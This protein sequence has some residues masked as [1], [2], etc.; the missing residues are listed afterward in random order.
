VSYDKNQ[1]E[2]YVHSSPIELPEKT[3]YLQV[4]VAPG[5][6]PATGGTPSEVGDSAQV[7]IPDISSF[8]KVSEMRTQIVR[9][10]KQVPEQVLTV[11]L[12]DEIETSELLENLSVYL[13]PKKSPRWE[14]L[15]EITDAVL[16]QSDVV[17]LHLIPN[18]RN[19][20]QV[21]NFTYDAP[22]SRQLY[23]HMAK[24]LKSINGFITSSFSAGIVSTPEYPREI[25]IMGDGAMLSLDGS[26][27]LSLLARG[28]DAYQVRVGKLL[29][30]Q[31][32]H[33]VS[34]TRGDISDV[35][36][37]NGY[38]DEENI[39]EYSSHVALL[40]ELHP[41]TANYTSIDLTSYL[42]TE[43]DSF[44]LFF[45][46]VAGW[47]TER[48]RTISGASDSRVILVTD[49]GLLVKDNSDQSHDV[50]VQSISNG[51]PVSDATVELLGR[52]GLPI[53]T[54]TTDADGHVSFPSTQGFS[55]E[56]TPT[57]Y[58]VKSG[59]DLSFLPF[60][61]SQRELN[62][63]QFEVGGVR[64]TT[65]RSNNL[66]AFL[67]SDR[68]LYRPGETV[69]L[70]GIVKGQNLANI[71]DIPL[72]IAIQD[73]RGV[74][75]VDSRLSLPEKGLLNYQ[76]ATDPTSETGTYEVMVYLVRDNK[77][78][79]EMIG[80]MT[81]R[82]E[83][84][85]P[86]TLK[87]ESRLQGVSAQGWS[88]AESIQAEVRMENMFG[89]AAQQRLVRAYLTVSAAQFKFPQYKGFTFT[90]PYYDPEQRALYVEES[91]ES[92]ETDQD[93]AALF[94]IP[95]D[96]F[97]RG[98]YQ[99][100]FQVEGFETGG[101]RSVTATN[102]ALISPLSVLLGYKSDGD[103]GYISKDAERHIDFVAISNEL[104]QIG[105]EDLTIR[106][107]SLQTI[108]TLVKQPNGTYSYQTVTRE[109]PG[110]AKPF[111]VA[112]EGLH[113]PLPTDIPGD[114][115]LEVQD[116]Q[117]LSLARISYSV[118][119]H[120]NLLGTIDKNA[121]LQLKLNKS[122]YKAGEQIEL[123]IKAPYVGAGLITIESD[124]VHA[125]KWFQTKTNSTLETITIPEGLEGNAYVNVAFVRD[126]GSKEIFTSPLSYAVAP[127]TLDRSQR[128]VDVQL[129]VEPLVRPGKA[130]KIGYTTSV[131]TKLIV[132]AVD[133][134][135]LQVANYQTPRPLDS[136]LK[137]RA[138]EVD[139][140]QIL[141]LILP[142]FDLVKE[143]S[144]S[145][146]GYAMSEAMR[147]LAKNL[148]PFARTVDS[149]AVFWS[150]ILDGS[151]DSASVEFNIPDT[152]SGSLR[153]MAIAV[154]DEAIGVTQESTLV[155][156]P[157][158]ITPSVLTQAAPGD[159]FK[160]SASVTNVLEGSGLE[161]P[162]TLR[163][164]ASEQLEV[165][166]STETLLHIDENS[167]QQVEFEVKVKQ[168]L[169]PAEIVFEASSGDEDIRR[170]AG[171]SIRPSVPYRTSISSGFAEDGETT[172][173]LQ[174]KLYDALSVQTGS[175]A[176]SPLVLVDGLETY[177]ENFPHG[178]TE[179]VISQTFPLLGLTGVSAYASDPSEIYERID[180]VVAKLRQRQLSQGGFGLWPGST[181]VA[182]FPSIYALHFLI[183]AL[184]YDYPVPN[185]VIVQGLEFLNDYAQR[186]SA[187]L[188]SARMRA[189]AIYLLARLGEI[190]TNDLVNLQ[191]YLEQ[192]YAQTWQKDVAAVY[193]AATYRL[194]QKD[195]EAFELARQYR[196]GEASWEGYST[197][198]SPLTLD[199]QALYLL[200][201]HFPEIAKSIDA[202]TIMNL[203]EPIF[204]GRY[205]TISAAYTI[206]ALGAYTET[207]EKDADDAGLAEILI[208]AIDAEGNKQVLP[209]ESE[210]FETVAIDNEVESLA[211]DSEQAFFY[212]VSQA[213]FDLQMPTDV[214]REGLEIIREYYDDEGNQ[215]EQMEQGK[216]IN[217][218]L[219]VRAL[220][221]SVANI[222]IID[223][224]P[225]G[226]EV[227]RDSVSRT[228]I[229]WRADYVDIR[230]DRVLFYGQFD[231]SI[232]E[233]TY[234]VKLTAAGSFVVPPI[235]AESMYDPSIRAG[236]ISQMFEVT[237]SK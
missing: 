97:D 121:E 118:V 190:V 13:L 193:M 64:G 173:S 156:G 151:Q 75:V 219:K 191:T 124:R 126:A 50:F 218:H 210:P 235:Y 164:M 21:F 179:Q 163:V 162:V 23:L 66:N 84:F 128:E 209:S 110:E 95:L 27:Q 9:N 225:G 6:A 170:T 83:E 48:D 99:L 35:S 221:K 82:V 78:R 79:S 127:F 56:Q 100:E 178:C 63:S 159:Q 77:Y 147:A 181:T 236:G 69:E 186:Q 43:E 80:S 47:D 5:V 76:F 198:N 166:G 46:E 104:E 224:L 117:D 120:G 234:R 172:T 81:F 54:R 7:L 195:A 14:N 233:L 237:P 31:L 20:S 130:M 223:L 216:E 137:K 107:I 222:A 175:A 232:T 71:E 59:S 201:L 24:G 45:I 153:V 140:L 111:S 57:S 93:G 183:E 25:N 188:Q 133:E 122:D 206:L 197:F 32:N 208:V 141:D 171:L 119:G 108:S 200:S 49:L 37:K 74:E 154:A 155:R 125:Y 134:G 116:N 187:S 41:Q 70:G 228:A 132:F 207:I 139:T 55:N 131:E 72:E 214:V 226:F 123:N 176:Q 168:K 4:T 88:S 18:A 160:I 148:N 112:T 231:T 65:S 149:P 185:D 42:P 11:E 30:G 182:E 146:G 51:K 52:N 157:F 96:R 29:P 114:Y 202:E 53:F 152:F 33:F 89:T 19:S 158:V 212:Q 36:F 98:T 217:V 174:R 196:M 17:E 142:E 16:E 26:H 103:L 211:F 192:D 60:Q 68:G 165:L 220:D 229:G 86:D 215:V 91:L 144:A 177:L 129:E 40:E 34:Q 44:G 3:N 136:F 205:N 113:Y 143:V 101:G 85:Q 105:L 92:Q 28:L 90:D 58:T 10:E 61:R 230:E 138:L 227:L 22:E 115:I 167:E 194:L 73:P 12:T 169:G 189:Y 2:A 135:I 204:E 109:E 39:V 1:R 62:Y 199:A 180:N 87:I 213:G 145:G 106:L 203:I 15:R 150:G 184:D 38:F 102:T 8:L 94:E 67:F 161:F